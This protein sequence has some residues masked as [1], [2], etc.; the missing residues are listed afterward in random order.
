MS[1]LR[2]RFSAALQNTSRSWRLAVDRRLKSF[3]MSQATWLTIAIV[4][5]AESPLSQTQLADKLGVEGAT[6]VA[7][8]DR[9]VKS[10]LVVREASTTDRRVKRVVLTAAGSDLYENVKTEAAAVRLELLA[11]V[12]PKALLGAT[13]LLELLQSKLDAKYL[14]ATGKRN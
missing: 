7:M 10:G 9:L 13:E 14:A 5:N 2:E 12:D 3:N 11:G 6:M 4:A 8:V 1:D